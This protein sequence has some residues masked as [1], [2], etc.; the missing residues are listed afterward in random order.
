MS[1][2]KGWFERLLAPERADRRSAP[3]FV[4]HSLNG[5]TIRKDAVRDIS[6]TGAYLLTED[7]LPQGT[8]IFLTMQ[9]E[10][11]PELSP[12]RRITALS[13]VARHGADGIGVEFVLPA[14]GHARQWANLVESL[15]QQTKPQEMPALLRICTAI[16]FL[17]R[18]C[19]MAS[20][21]ME[22]L[23]R[24]RLSNHKIA[25]A[26]GIAHQAEGLLAS[27]PNFDQLR[28]DTELV[29]RILE[30]GACADEEWLRND[31]AGLLASCCGSNRSHEAN[32]CVVDLFSQLTVA[33]IRI[34]S[35]ICSRNGK[36]APSGNG[37]SSAAPSAFKTEELAFGI[38]LREAQI[39]R[40][41][42]ILSDLGLLK[43]GFSDSRALL[44]TDTV[45]LAPTPLALSLHARLRGQRKDS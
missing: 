24:G 8:V 1:D 18:I 43:K 22:Q 45:E 21:D 32:L 12:S 33:Q 42:E 34:V 28:A 38:S 2:R 40:D 11:A 41:L 17:S 31:W 5:S 25:N 9:K 15:I 30:V 6:T 29:I 35:S 3:Q 20:D 4:A 19:P 36:A 26:V 10:G 27:Q 37:A 14:D 23:F 39:E 13:R 7:R 16:H 44:F